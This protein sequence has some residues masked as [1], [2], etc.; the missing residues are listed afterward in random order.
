MRLE[1][2]KS[3][4]GIEFP[5]VAASPFRK[6]MDDF[7]DRHAY[8]CLP[9]NI[10]NGHAWHILC[11]FRV[12]ISWNGGPQISDLEVRTDKA[13]QTHLN[14]LIRSNFS[15]GVA[16]FHTGYLFRTEPNWNLLVSGPFNH[17]KD[18]I[19]PLTAI[20]ETDWLPYPFTMNWLMTRP[21]TVAFEKDEPI[22]S[23]MPI[24]KGYIEDVTPEIFNMEDDPVLKYEEN[25][26]REERERFMKKLRAGDQETGKRAW[27]KHYF[28]GRMPDGKKPGQE[29]AEQHRNKLRLQEPVDKRGTKP[30]LALEKARVNFEQIMEP[31]GEKCPVTGAAAKQEPAAPARKFS[32][33]SVLNYISHEQSALNIAGRQN[34]K[35]GKLVHPAMMHIDDIDEELASGLDFRV[36]DGFLS[37]EDCALLVQTV[38]DLRVNMQQRNSNNDYWQGR[39][40]YPN[41][42]YETHKKSADIIVDAIHRQTKNIRK[43]YEL[44]AP[45]WCDTVNL[46]YWPEGLAMPPH[47]D[48]A[49][50]DGSPHGMPWRDF[51]SICYLNEDFKGGEVYFT[52]LNMSI[53]PKTGRNISFTG[54]FHHEHSVLKV[55]KGNRFTLAAFYTLNE[56]HKDPWI[57]SRKG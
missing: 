50:P 12:E 7:T 36:E 3:E 25:A 55:L 29:I 5:L 9:L 24:P 28:V 49:N 1:C 47:A 52:A 42:I 2:F 20:V 8:R 51:A 56:K 15:R 40:L 27:Q 46:A 35:D 21:G 31:S 34:V 43:F 26:F 44:E 57:Y 53:R 23:I 48:N 13:H 19:F 39:V 54:G 41:D 37:K 18:G 45:I 30:A 32:E 33:T 4:R 6:W 22:C 11:P 17:A 14:T 16:T 38:R 10:A